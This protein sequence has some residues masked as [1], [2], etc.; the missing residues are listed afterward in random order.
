MEKYIATLIGEVDGYATVREFKAFASAVA[1]L[2]GAGLAEY[3]DQ[4]ARGEVQAGDG[5][6][7]WAKS[8]LE[9]AESRERNKVLEGQRLLAVLGWNAKDFR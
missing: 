1:W 8:R 6:I 2:Q 4:T 7:V 3:G 9:T 5:Q